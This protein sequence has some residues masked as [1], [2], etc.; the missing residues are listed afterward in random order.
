MFDLA[1][2]AFD[3]IAVSIDHRIDRS[4]D[5]PVALGRD[6]RPSAAS[7]DKV[8][9]VLPV[10]ASIGDDKR[11]GRETVKQGRRGRLVGRL[12]GCQREAYRQPAL[13][14]DGM[15]FGGQSSTRAADG[16]IRT[17]FLPPAACW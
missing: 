12:A 17:P 14:D 5:L 3:K 15:D 6:L 9:Q 13:V 8:D 2:E 16:V 4:L 10:I 7:L 11:S 1:E